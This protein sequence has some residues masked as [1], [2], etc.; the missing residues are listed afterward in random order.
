MTLKRYL[1][2]KSIPVSVNFV[3]VTADA[4]LICEAAVIFKEIDSMLFLK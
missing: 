3:S 4:F 1:V 2:K